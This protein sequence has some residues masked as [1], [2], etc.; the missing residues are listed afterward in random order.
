ML[1]SRDG[2]V[3]RV[4]EVK[5]LASVR[6]REGD[7]LLSVAVGSTKD[8]VIFFS[9][10]GAAYVTRIVDIPATT[11]YGEPMQKLFK[12]DDGESVVG[13]LSL[14]PRVPFPACKDGK[15]RLMAVKRDGMALR[16]ELDPHTELSTRS[17]RRFCRAELGSEVVGVAPVVDGDTLIVATQKAQVL[18]CKAAEVNE[19]AGAGKGVTAI[20]VA[21]GDRVIGFAI[22]HGRG[23]GITLETDSG[24]QTIVTPANTEVTSRGG[25]GQ[26][27]FKRSEVR[28]I[29]PPVAMFELPEEPGKPK[30]GE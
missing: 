25:K 20:K 19:L 18:V 24:R 16:F 1:L 2:W 26:A 15:K 17:G 28:F 8:L 10:F 7:S 3:R 5:D 13:M 12:F 22:P 9:S 29:P 11:G 27:V 30:A 4:R 21:D 23:D 6:L 14:D